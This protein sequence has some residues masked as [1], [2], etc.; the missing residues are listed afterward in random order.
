MKNSKK[1][2]MGKADLIF[3]V[4]NTGFQIFCI[5]IVLYPL[6]YI[7]SASFSSPQAVLSGLVKFL[8]VDFSLEG[9]KAVFRHRYIMSGYMNTITYTAFGTLLSVTLTIMAGYPL[10]RRDFYGNKALMVFFTF[11]MLFSG[12]MIPGY[13]LVYSLGLIDS[14]LAMVIP[15][16]L[17]AWYVFI[18][19]T[20][21]KT[22]IPEDLYEA[23]VLDGCSDIKFLL[24]IVLPISKAII[25]VLVLFYSV[26]KWN[27]Y[28]AALLYLRTPEKY[29]LQLILRGILIL[30]QVQAEMLQDL[31]EVALRQGLEALLKYSLIVVASAPMLILYPFVQKHFV[32]GMMIGSLKG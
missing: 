32:K 17:S 10:S 26:S 18:A 15:G 29:P 27:S 21:F 7:V 25:A 5:L 31:E 6:I 4:F 28:M 1:V 12:G 8:P 13:L 30:S 9:Y 19:R 20:F 11:T 3:T 2:R 24:N 16:A 14:R 23:A 22:T